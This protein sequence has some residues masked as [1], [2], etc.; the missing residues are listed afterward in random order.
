MGGRKV[1]IDFSIFRAAAD[2]LYSGPWV[3]ER[4]AAI[5][6]FMQCHAD[7]MHPVVRKIIAGASRYTAVDAFKS[8]YKL[9]ELRRAS[10]KEWDRMDVL[11]L[12][13]TG[14]T[15]THEAVE[16]DPI[17][18][19][20]NLG[21]YTNFVNLLD[22][23]A[24]AIPAGFRRNGLPFG[25]SLIGP[26]FCDEALLVLGDRFGHT[27]SDAPLPHFN[28]DAELGPRPPGCVEIAVVGAHLSGQPLNRHLKE[29]GSRLLRTTR[30]APGYRLFALDTS[31]AKPG[32]VREDDYRG[33]GIE[34]EVWAMPEDRFGGF[35]DA[36]PSPLVIGNVALHD[37]ASVKGFLCEPAAIESAQE[38]TRHGGW[39][40]YLAYASSM[41]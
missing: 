6:G 2:L 26:A 12:P 15:Y 9:R 5:N 39:R 18:L 16:A 17:Q 13:T 28:L 19:N 22:L 34:V 11:L 14:T 33:P 24:V 8:E 30:T 10:Q 1:E 4:M 35:V 32:L 25:V 37:G 27:R 40:G 36:V 7:E 38:I 41:K 20:T 31:P 3:A 21:F 23:A 29:R